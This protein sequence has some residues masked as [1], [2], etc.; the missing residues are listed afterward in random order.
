MQK[1]IF[2]YKKYRHP[3]DNTVV[4]ILFANHLSLILRPCIHPLKFHET[5]SNPLFCNFIC[6]LQRLR[7]GRPLLTYIILL[8]ITSA[9]AANLRETLKIDTQSLRIPRDNNYP[10]RYAPSR[11]DQQPI[12]GFRPENTLEP[13]PSLPLE[14]RC[15]R[16]DPI[17]PDYRYES[18]PRY[19]DD[20]DRRYRDR[21]YDNYPDDRVR[22]YNRYD[23]YDRYDR[24]RYYPERDRYNERRPYDYDDR[25]GYG[26]DRYYDRYNSNDRGLG[27]DNRGYDYRAASDRGGYRPWD[28]T[29][30]GASGWDN[31][32]RG[33]YFASGRPSAD[34]DPYGYA[35]K[36][37]YGTSGGGRDDYYDRGG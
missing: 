5:F 35:S 6:V 20:Y 23:G 31:A 15:S 2:L 30:R 28:Q 10:S 12:R 26:R 7:C 32:G 3:S 27:Y 36:W 17:Y 13:E 9:N 8:I 25:D 16:C 24:D 14:K 34:A 22:D 18:R 1:T 11:E 19:Y 37:S 29:T 33:Y 4:T 21:Y